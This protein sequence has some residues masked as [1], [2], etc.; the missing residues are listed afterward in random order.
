LPAAADEVE[1]PTI[2]KLTIDGKDVREAEICINQE[3]EVF[4]EISPC[5]SNFA[6][7]DDYDQDYFEKICESYDGYEYYAT[8]RA[9]DVAVDDAGITFGIYDGEK[10]YDSEVSKE[11]VH[12]SIRDM[13]ESCTDDDF[14]LDIVSP[15][16]VEEEKVVA[17]E[18]ETGISESEMEES[19]YEI[20][21]H[22]KCEN[23]KSAILYGNGVKGE[24]EPGL[25]YYGTLKIVHNNAVVAEKEFD[26]GVKKEDEESSWSSRDRDWQQTG[27]GSYDHEI[28]VPYI[29]F[30]S[31]PEVIYWGERLN[32]D[33][34]RS[35]ILTDE[36][37][38]I[39]VDESSQST[40]ARELSYY[41]EGSE[42][43]TQK[44]ELHYT[45]PMKVRVEVYDS[46]GTKLLKYDEFDFRVNRRVSDTI[47][48][49]N[50][51]SVVPTPTVEEPPV[52]PSGEKTEEEPGRITR[53]L[54]GI[55][56]YLPDC[57]K[58]N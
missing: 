55:W 48:S 2:T 21:W 15:C 51:S 29:D 30:G 26:F 42:W 27:S 10:E 14:E 36:V 52:P 39:Y 1:D 50:Q 43:L 18:V 35:D 28:H 54:Y 22:I 11:A 5:R 58:P 7:S 40:L 6:I 19:G 56:D 44:F 20:Q 41:K 46:T 31:T 13:E 12:F 17:F 25:L 16:M 3:F 32:V 8:Y 38:K 4:V 33:L 9:K 34:T 57:L 47:E 24:F 23:G 37:V 45:G 49:E 53:I